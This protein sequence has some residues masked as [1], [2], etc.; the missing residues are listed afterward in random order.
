TGVPSVSIADV[1]GGRVVLTAAYGEQS[2]GVPAS[3][4]TLYNLASL[5]KPITAETVL[6]LA[7]E[8]ALSLDEP[9]APVWTDPDIAKD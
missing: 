4:A 7:G 8:G 3:P 6:R 2:R 9:M 1:E 5:T